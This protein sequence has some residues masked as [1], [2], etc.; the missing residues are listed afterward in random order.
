MKMTCHVA[1]FNSNVIARQLVQTIAHEVIN[2]RTNHTG[3]SIQDSSVDDALSPFRFQK[4]H[5][6]EVSDKLWPWLSFYLN[7]VKGTIVFGAGRYSAPNE[8]L[9]LLVLNR[10][11]GFRRSKIPAGIK[12][13]ASAMHTP[14]LKYLDDPSIFFVRMPQYV[15]IINEKCGLVNSV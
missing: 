10:F 15:E 12:T 13:M 6:Q 7:G 14:V 1:L 3:L 4:E 9:F 11:F 2:W 8:T 5:L